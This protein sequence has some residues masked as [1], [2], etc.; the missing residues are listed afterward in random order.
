MEKNNISF[1]GVKI[2]IVEDNKINM[3]LAERIL[4]EQG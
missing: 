2:L 3:D 1:E 4:Q